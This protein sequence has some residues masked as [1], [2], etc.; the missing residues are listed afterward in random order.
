M[1]THLETPVR[2][3]NRIVFYNATTDGQLIN[4]ETQTEEDIKDPVEEG[5][6]KVSEINGAL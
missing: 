3:E 2:P 1:I 6:R 4:T 5:Y